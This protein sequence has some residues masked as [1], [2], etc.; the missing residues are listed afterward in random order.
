M[1]PGSGA[2][3][4]EECGAAVL[5]FFFKE[6]RPSPLAGEGCEALASASELRRSRVRGTRRKPCALATA[7]RS[8]HELAL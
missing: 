6:E 8:L 2:G 1:D 7:Q 4:T 3:V 5:R